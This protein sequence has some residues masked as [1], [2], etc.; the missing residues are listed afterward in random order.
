[1][2]RVFLCL[3]VI[4]LLITP[5][6]AHPKS[7]RL[8]QGGSYTPS[9]VRGATVSNFCSAALNRDSLYDKYGLTGDIPHGAS[10]ASAFDFDS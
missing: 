9:S 7:E 8:L 4:L 2:I 6:L 3:A 5:N 10:V 1:M